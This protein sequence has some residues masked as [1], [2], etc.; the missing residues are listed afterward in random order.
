MFGVSAECSCDDGKTITRNNIEVQ[1]GSGG[2][3]GN[4]IPASWSQQL[5]TKSIISFLLS[6]S[7]WPRIQR[8]VNP[9]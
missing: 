6:A 7:G 3:R 2:L 9:Q 5:I 1:N 8:A 4:I